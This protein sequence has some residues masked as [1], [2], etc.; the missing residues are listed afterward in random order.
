MWARVGI[1][2]EESVSTQ[3]YGR[4][5][6]GTDGCNRVLPEPSAQFQGRGK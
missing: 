5:E 1:T 2:A 3:W 4:T 6:R